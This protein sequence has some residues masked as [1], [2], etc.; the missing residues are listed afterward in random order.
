LHCVNNIITGGPVES[1]V[2]YLIEPPS[3][4]GFIRHVDQATGLPEWAPF[5]LRFTYPG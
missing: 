2:S 3:K 5:T 1:H 4:A